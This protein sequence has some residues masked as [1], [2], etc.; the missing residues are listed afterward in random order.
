MDHVLVGTATG[1]VTDQ[2]DVG[3]Y[4]ATTYLVQAGAVASGDAFDIGVIATTNGTSA[5][6]ADA[7]A[8]RAATVVNLTGTVGNDT[9]TT[10]A[11]N[12]TISGGSGNDVI[13]GGA[14]GDVLDGGSGNDTY[15]LVSATD[16]SLA[17]AAT[18][19]V[20]IDTIT[21]GTGDVI[22]TDLTETLGALGAL[23]SV[24]LAAG[25]EATGATLTAAIAAAITEVANAAFLIK[26]TD[27]S[28]DSSFDGGFTGYYLAICADTTFSSNDV[29]IKLSGVSDTTTI[30]VATGGGIGLGG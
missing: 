9:L 1:S 22:N 4:L 21:L 16:S 8:A 15:T 18:S 29:L 2:G 12:D 14:G 26:V 13:T 27:S 10:G 20:G 25:S 23:T 24:A 5:A 6:F 3:S 17:D 30:A 19:A 28:T 11:N 7:T